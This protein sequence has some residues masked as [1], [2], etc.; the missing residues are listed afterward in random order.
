MNINLIGPINE[1]SYG[2]VCLNILKSLTDLGNTVSLFPIT[3]HKDISSHFIPYIQTAL[4]NA[5]NPDL[6]APSIRIWHQ[7]DMS[8]F[9]GNGPRIGFPIFELDGFTPVELN[10]LNSLQHCFVCSQWAKDILVKNTVLKNQ[11]ISVIPL[12]VDEK[13]FYPIPS[14]LDGNQPYKFLNVGKWEVR[15]GHDILPDIFSSAFSTHDNVQLYMCNHNIHLND[16]ENKEWERYYE[17]KIPSHQLKFIPRVKTQNDL[18]VLMNN[19]DCGIFPSRAE[20]WNLEAI[21]MLACGKDVI[22]THNTAHTEYCQSLPY[23]TELEETEL[24]YDGKWFFNQGLWWKIG[25]KNI[26]TLSD[27]MRAAFNNK[28]KYNATNSAVAKKYVWSETGTR[29]CNALQNDVGKQ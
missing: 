9:V 26:K 6:N 22:L 18:C 29:I 27:M 1:T 20:G 2:L 8:L 11:Q 14:Q 21:E 15:K 4:Q 24:A 10:H 12:G 7:F 3:I 28:G 5:K 13:I 16:N 17:S 25:Q 23:T 19:V